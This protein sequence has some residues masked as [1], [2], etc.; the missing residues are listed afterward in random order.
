MS[1]DPK[2]KINVIYLPNLDGVI[3]HQTLK[4]T[5]TTFNI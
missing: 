2:F 3:T 5:A 1:Y 4:I